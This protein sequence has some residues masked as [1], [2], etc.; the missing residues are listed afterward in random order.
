MKTILA[1]KNILRL[2]LKHKKGGRY[3]LEQIKI[4]GHG[5]RMKFR[6]INPDKLMKKIKMAYSN[7]FNLA[8]AK[9]TETGGLSEAI[10]EFIKWYNYADGVLIKDDVIFF[11]FVDVLMSS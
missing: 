7:A 6:I 3:T 9:Y 8:S 5:L 2:L 1:Y 10:V 11:M 4:D